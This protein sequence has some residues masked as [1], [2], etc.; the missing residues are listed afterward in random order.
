M[1][2]P[3]EVRDAYSEYLQGKRSLDEVL[4]LAE[5]KR[6]S[7]RA[8]RLARREQ[9]PEEIEAEEAEWARMR[10]SGRAAPLREAYQRYLDGEC[11][12]DDVLDFADHMRAGV[13]GAGSPGAGVSAGEEAHTVSN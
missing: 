11:S 6:E 7:T 10:A 8:E 13:R 3:D 1:K 5:R 2:S 4:D 12:L 9:T